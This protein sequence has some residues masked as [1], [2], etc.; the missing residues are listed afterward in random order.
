MLKKKDKYSTKTC[1]QK[2]NQALVST[3]VPIVIL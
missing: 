3:Q 2:K 1:K